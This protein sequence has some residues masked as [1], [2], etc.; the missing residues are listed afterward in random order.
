MGGP[1]LVRG[2]ATLARDLP[3]LLRGH[4]CEPAA[5]LTFSWLS[6]LHSFIHGSTLAL[7][8]ACPLTTYGD[9]FGSAGGSWTG[10]G[11][12]SF[13]GITGVSSGTSRGRGSGGSGPGSICIISG[14]LSL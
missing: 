7:L 10:A 4:R 9:V 14:T 3:L 8:A 6:T 1:L 11:L 2:P 13:G 5:F 12:G